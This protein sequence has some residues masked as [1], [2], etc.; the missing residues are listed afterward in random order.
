MPLLPASTRRILRPILAAVLVTILLLTPGCDTQV[1]ILDPSDQYRFSL[2]GA[3]NVA[4]DTQVIRVEPLADAMQIGA[5][6]QFDG[7]VLLENMENETQVTMRDSFAMVGTR[8]VH[9]HNFWTTHSIQP[10]TSYRVTVRSDGEPVT[11]ATTTTPTH[12]PELTHDGGFILPCLFPRGTNDERRAQ[13]TFVVRARN[14]EH[15]A[16]ANVIYPITYRTN[17]GPLRTRNVFSHYDTVQDEGEFFDIYVFYRPD[18]ADLNPDPP[19]GPRQ[20]CAGRREFTH[21]YALVSVA[22]GGPNW[23]DDW[24]GLPVDEIASTNSFSNVQGGHG[25]VAG[26]YSDTIRVPIQDRY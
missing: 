17:Q 14:I 22:A 11:T 4:A 13:N 6:R 20:E 24:R 26:V 3:L 19:P 5:P 18:L 15:L 1:D 21:P 12:P 8:D 23:P 10:S 16:S 25:F 7:T 2:F 9:V